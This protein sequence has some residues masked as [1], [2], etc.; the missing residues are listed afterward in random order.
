MDQLLLLELV[1]G[2]AVAVASYAVLR[3]V[4]AP[5]LR[6]R[7]AQPA[8]ERPAPASGLILDDKPTQPVLAWVQRATGLGESAEGHK[9]KRDLRLAGFEHPAARP[10]FVLVRFCLA[11]ILPFILIGLQSV[12]TNPL[13]KPAFVL[14]CTALGILGFSI[15]GLYVG[16]TA[17]SR[18]E[19]IE[20]QFPDALDL[21]VVCIEAG[22]GLDTAFIRVGRE[23]RGSHPRIS[24]ELERLAIELR[25]G[26][27]RADALRAF[28]ERTDAQAVKAF[29]AL[30][31][32][33]DRL[34]TSVGQTLR[35]Y[36]TEMRGARYLEAEKK[37]M[38]VPV[39][40]T[41]PLIVF[42][43]PVV[44]AALLLP[45]M[46]D[47]ARVVMPSMAHGGQ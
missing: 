21:L 16:R 17:A 5:A 23:T 46:L 29:V 34:G 32:Q 19:Q 36:S 1:V 41:I 3:V 24:W 18:R 35:A 6:P 13:P 27:T 30:M 9:L 40:M 44:I 38:R 31:I 33:T 11:L 2:L 39:L 22:L 4:K 45:P 14:L 43:L 15:P 42:I 25:A 10:L 37:A 47:I 28:A 26:R 7:A 12:S 20:H 8:A